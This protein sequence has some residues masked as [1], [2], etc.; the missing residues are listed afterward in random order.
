LYNNHFKGK[1]KKIP[2]ALS[3][4]KIGKTAKIP[5]KEN[6]LQKKNRASWFLAL[7]KSPKKIE[8]QRVNFQNSIF[9]KM[10]EN[11]ERIGRSIYWSRK[12]T[13][14]L[15]LNLMRFR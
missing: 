7:S 9:K 11:S 12:K 13:I 1:N 10:Q 15:G 2:G 6:L 14:R 4:L 8:T 5:K 3:E